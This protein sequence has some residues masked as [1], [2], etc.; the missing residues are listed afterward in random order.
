MGI[1]C[2]EVHIKRNKQQQQKKHVVDDEV[3]ISVCMCKRAKIGMSFSVYA[4][5]H[6]CMLMH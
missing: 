6:W 2:F 5:S 1:K 3:A 4:V